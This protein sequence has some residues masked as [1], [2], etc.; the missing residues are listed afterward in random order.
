MLTYKSILDETLEAWEDARLGVI[1]EAQNIPASKFDFRPAPEVRS[2]KGQVVHILE[3]AMMMT[4]ELTRA[5]TNFRRADW[6]KLLKMYAAE[7]YRAESKAELMKLLKS[8]LQDGVKKFR[9]AGELHMLQF[10]QRFDGQPGTRMAW[11]NHGIAQEMYH[12]GQL[13][14]YERLLG[15][16]P[17]LTKLIRGG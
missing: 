5:D 8:Q 4:G 12:R 2:V 11:L 16:E 15:I 9:D 17:A 13:C 10:I 7:A 3:V 6:S 14:L 1:A